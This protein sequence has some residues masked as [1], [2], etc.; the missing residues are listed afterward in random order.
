MQQT[1]ECGLCGVPMT[2]MA[3]SES[4]I[5]YY[6]CPHC[7]GWCASPY[8]SDAM[9][10]GAIRTS[11]G[12]SRTQGWDSSFETIKGR[13]EQWL[14]TVDAEAYRTPP[15]SPPPV[16]PQASRPGRWRDSRLGTVRPKASR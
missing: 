5:R 10:N 11:N 3:S 16:A 6:R 15:V 9:R 2:A 14:K 1:F 4:P 13:L 8:R 12:T 7:G